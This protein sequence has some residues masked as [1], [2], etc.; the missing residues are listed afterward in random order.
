MSAFTR[1][2]V[3]RCGLT[4]LAGIIVAG[5]I[6][7]GSARANDTQGWYLGAGVGF[8]HMPAFNENVGLGT[9]VNIATQDSA[10][11]TGSF[12]YRFGDRVRL[13]MEIG[14]EHHDVSAPFTGHTQMVPI[15]INVLY[16]WNL[17]NNFIF[18]AGVGAGPASFT[19]CTAAGAAPCTG[20][21]IMGFNGQLIGELSYPV[22]PNLFAYV[23][24]FERVFLSGGDVK[25]V[26][27]RGFVLGLRWFV[28][29]P[30]PP[31]PPR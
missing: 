3:L 12:G 14:W 8:D 1:N 10:I 19:Y 11:V 16:D 4:A 25:Q 22:Q 6:G 28:P 5:S 2:G 29:N 23:Q 20:A 18:S 21:T 13:E 31:P 27:D 15:D 26:N 24:G 30:P 17:G 7:V 9:L